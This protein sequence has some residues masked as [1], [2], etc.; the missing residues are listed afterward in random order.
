[1][2]AEDSTPEWFQLAKADAFEPKPKNKRVLRAMALA[3]PLFV[4]GAGMVFA[5]TQDSPTASASS[6]VATSAATA[7]PISLSTTPTATTPDSAPAASEPAT[8][9]PAPRSGSNAVSISQTS[10]VTP[11]TQTSITIKKPAI[12]MP[13]GG[14]DDDERDSDDD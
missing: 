6:L 12:T 2:K 9:A 4:L 8:S 14:G 7:D 5:Q 11:T 1:M 3:T 13:T 10:S